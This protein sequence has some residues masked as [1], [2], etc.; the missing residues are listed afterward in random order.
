MKQL[1]GFYMRVLSFYK[2]KGGILIGNTKLHETTKALRCTFPNHSFNRIAK[3]NKFIVRKR[4]LEV[5][6]FLL[7][8]VSNQ[9]SVGNDTLNDLCKKLSKEGVRISPH[10]LNERFNKHAESFLR[11]IFLHLLNS[12]NFET[13]AIHTC[14]FSRIRI[15]DS[16]SFSLPRS[17]SSYRG[18]TKSGVKIQLEYDIL[19]GEIL[20]IEVQEG[21]EREQNY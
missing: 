16:T 5:L 2:V 8:C 9:V 18:S 4:N 13:Q 17:Y 11:Q 12:V 21:R 7:L 19:S 15:L 3:E 20:L 1:T 14:F 10:G 6:P